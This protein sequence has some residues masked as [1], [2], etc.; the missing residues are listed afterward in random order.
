MFHY[1]FQNFFYA[2]LYNGLILLLAYI[3]FINV[4]VA[5]ILFTC[6]VKVAL[7]PLS[8]KSIRTQ[9]EMKKMEPEMNEI[10]AKY[11]D[12]KQAQAEK[13]M[14]LYKEKN[15]NPFSGIALMFIQLP[16]LIALYY[17]FLRG[18][19][20]NIDHN[21]LY[22]FVK[23]PDMVN[24]MFFGIDITKTSTIF[25]VFAALAQFFQMQLTI[26]KT[27]KKAKIKG[28]KDDFK[29]ELAKSMNMQMKYVMPVIIFLVARS[30]PVVVSLYLITGSVFAIGQEFYM[31]RGKEAKSGVTVI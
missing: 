31:R 27:P 25:A 4:G 22:S 3:P 7:F 6:I 24:M 26:P 28:Q 17:V 9:L 20:P 29:D 11:K 13:I 5:V 2:P 18:G 12:N 21:V 30:F 19:L 14:A 8:K 23:A 16:V 15:L 10:K 1:I